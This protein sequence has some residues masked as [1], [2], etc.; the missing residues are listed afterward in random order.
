[1]IVE[2]FDAIRRR[3]RALK[4]GLLSTPAECRCPPSGI[5]SIGIAA[6]SVGNRFMASRQ[7]ATVPAT[8]PRLPPTE[9]DLKLTSNAGSVSLNVTV[10]A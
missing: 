7:P 1:M 8:S 10:H 3:L 9:A 5:P 6:G 4:P 2:D